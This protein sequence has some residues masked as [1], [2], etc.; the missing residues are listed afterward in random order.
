MAMQAEEMR[1]Q[2]YPK[3]IE[4]NRKLASIVLVYRYDRLFQL[5]HRADE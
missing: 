2:T 3:T 4:A 5:D 1:D